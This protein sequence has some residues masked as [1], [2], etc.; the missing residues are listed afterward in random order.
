MEEGNDC[1]EG[2]EVPRYQSHKKVW[3]HKIKEIDTDMP[4]A[5]G[6]E[7]ARSVMITPCEEGY[8]PF[9]V[10]FEYFLKHNPKVGGYYVVYEG[11][12]K[13]YSPPGP[14]ES[15]YTKIN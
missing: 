10:S 11:G 9:N 12:Y 6:E 4:I 8:A 15:G 14:F 1:C 5:E 13:S 7:Q 3:A 2:R